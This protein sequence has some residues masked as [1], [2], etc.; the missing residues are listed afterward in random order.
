VGRQL[1]AGTAVVA[2][3]DA[4]TWFQSEFATGATPQTEII[5]TTSVSDA[6][7]YLARS[8]S[9]YYVAD[10]DSE[11]YVYTPP[12]LTQTKNMGVTGQ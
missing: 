5:V 1:F 12:I 11:M 7:Q 3:A 2:G 8:T 9:I 6:S 10:A 4:Y